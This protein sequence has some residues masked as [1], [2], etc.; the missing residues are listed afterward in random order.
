M[1]FKLPKDSIAPMFDEDLEEHIVSC[2]AYNLSEPAFSEFGTAY[3]K[4]LFGGIVIN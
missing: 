1:A 2:Y 4:S 3:I